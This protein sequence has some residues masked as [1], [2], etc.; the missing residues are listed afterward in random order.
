[1]ADQKPGAV[2]LICGLD[3]EGWA[4]RDEAYA[5]GDEDDAEPALPGDG[6]VEPET[7]EEGYDDV[8]EGGC[9]EDEGEVGPG[10]RGEI[11]GEEA[12]Q[13]CDAECDPGREDGGDERG[14]MGERDGRQG[15]YAAREARV[16]ER[17]AESDKAQDHVLARG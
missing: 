8:A 15:G 11:A 16:S 5:D 14:G 17:G 9:G 12:D 10:E 7:G 6:F 4:V 3:C 1:V 2:G 13:E